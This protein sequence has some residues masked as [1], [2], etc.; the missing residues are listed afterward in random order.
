VVGTPAR[1]VKLNGE[2]TDLEL[3]RM[4]PSPEAEPV[5]LEV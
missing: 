5:E 3:P 1:I 4:A 2:R